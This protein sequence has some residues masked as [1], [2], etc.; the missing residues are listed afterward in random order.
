MQS[1]WQTFEQQA[2][3]LYCH[4]P[5]CAHRCKYCA[6]YQEMPASESVERY[7]R[8]IEKEFSL[9]SIGEP[10]TS[11]YIG[12]GT[13]GILTAAN[14]E[15]LCQT[16]LQNNST[17]KPSEFS[18]E[19]SPATVR[20][21]KIEIAQNYSCNRITVGIQSFSA[22]TLQ[23][24]GRRQTS[25][26]VADACEII[27]SSGIENIGIDLIFGV[28]NQTLEEW[29]ADLRCAINLK[30]KHI[31]TYN[32]TFEDGTELQQNLTS[33]EIA[34]KSSGEEID[35]YLQTCKFLESNGYEQ[36]EISNFCLPGFE[37]IHNSNTWKMQNWIGIGPSACSQC[38]GRRFANPLSI[39][40]W[41]SSLECNKLAHENIEIIDEK[42]FA[43]DSVIFGLRMN[44]GIDLHHLKNKFK[45]I[46][47][48][49]LDELF[50]QLAAENL[51]QMRGE[52]I[53][54]TPNGR[55]VADAIAVEILG[56]L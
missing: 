54:L 22:K 35:F 39:E 2:L 36:Y 50:F 21:E 18:I 24:L 37:S 26:Q 44:R 48:S 12:G 52:F 43:L 11:I 10:F 30:P 4:V 15:R 31:S 47:F 25:R 7:L 17:A 33:N 16:L 8:G 3:G 23:T 32:L 14:L 19:F 49:K 20:R 41:L 42:N 51:L 56:K 1:R 45:R 46:D 38:N 29:L 28:P 55:L 34:Q 9:L 5:F 40:K 13:P 53:Q 27:L 6:F